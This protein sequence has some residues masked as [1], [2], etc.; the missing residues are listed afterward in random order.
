[1][2]TIFKKP[3]LENAMIADLLRMTNA[4]VPQLQ[5]FLYHLREV[6]PAGCGGLQIWQSGGGR[7]TSWRHLAIDQPSRFLNLGACAVQADRC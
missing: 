6:F 3:D 1:M 2:F 5:D 7:N 4:K